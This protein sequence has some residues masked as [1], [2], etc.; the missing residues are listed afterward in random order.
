[1]KREVRLAV[2]REVPEA[3]C[4]ED[5]GRAPKHPGSCKGRALQAGDKKSFPTRLIWER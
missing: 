4:G 5:L 1:M 3:P 2:W